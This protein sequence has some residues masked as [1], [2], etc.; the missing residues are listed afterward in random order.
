ME[1]TTAILADDKR[2]FIDKSGAWVGS[3]PP[4]ALLAIAAAAIAVIL[5]LVMLL[6]IRWNGIVW[7]YFVYEIVVLNTILLLSVHKHECICRDIIDLES[8]S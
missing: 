8:Q 5:F 2:V 7:I 6:S 1:P 4:A 3:I